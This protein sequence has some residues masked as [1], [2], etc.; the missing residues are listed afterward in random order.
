MSPAE[1]APAALLSRA[2]ALAGQRDKQGALLAYRE[3][4]ARCRPEPHVPD[5]TLEARARVGEAMALRD[6]ERRS[7]ELDAWRAMVVRFSYQAQSDDPAY[8]SAPTSSL[9]PFA[10]QAAYRLAEA[11]R[12]TQGGEASLSAFDEVVATY[13]SSLDPDV[14]RWAAAAMAGRALL[15]GKRGQL[16]EE[17]LEHERIIERFDAVAGP[18]ETPLTRWIAGAWVNRAEVLQGLRR[19]DEASACRSAVLD[20]FAGS[21][22]P[23]VRVVLMTA[24]LNLAAA[25]AG[26]GDHATALAAC[27]DLVSRYAGA[28]DA[29]CP[30]PVQEAYVT[31]AWCLAATGRVEEAILAYE[32]LIARG[33]PDDDAE[34]MDRMAGAMFEKARALLSLG[35]N[36]LAYATLEQLLRRYGGVR[37]PKVASRVEQARLLLPFRRE[38]VG[39]LDEAG[40]ADRKREE[41][42]WSRFVFVGTPASSGSSPLGRSSAMV[43]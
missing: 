39:E 3:A 25:A 8:R 35:R 12:D 40:R 4:V 30:A 43:R 27:D 31:K 2:D 23:E 36:S 18:P 17:L 22:D 13:A 28:R 10:A 5:A 19:L 24:L 11:V 7:E 41:A 21:V 29:S 34:T 20:R 1:P 9:V 15:L 14:L 42:R 16:S 38:Q 33:K 26:H 6:L 37:D 32:G